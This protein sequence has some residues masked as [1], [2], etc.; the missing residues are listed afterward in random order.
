MHTQQLQ[1]L[2]HTRLLL[3]LTQLLLQQLLQNKTQTPS[4]ISEF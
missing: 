3:Q 4:L 1:R 2:M